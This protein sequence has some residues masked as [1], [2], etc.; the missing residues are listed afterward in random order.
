M[1]RTPTPTRGRVTIDEAAA[2]SG[3]GRDEVYR[4]IRLGRIASAVQADDGTW[5][6]SR[7]DARKLERHRAL[8]APT[9]KAYQL[10]VPLDR[11]AAW[12]AEA[13]R[14][15]TTVGILAMELMDRAAGWTGEE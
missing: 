14:R 1:T 6:I 13:K 5:T 11:A 3:L 7:S 9:R 15:G 12:E 2:I 8:V 4:R 10:R